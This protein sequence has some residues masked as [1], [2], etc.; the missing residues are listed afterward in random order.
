MSYKSFGE[1]LHAKR[2]EKGVSYRE[3]ADVIDVTAPYIS[4]MEKGRRNAPVMNKLK[5]ISAY[6]GLSEEEEKNMF[7]LA[8]KTKDD[9]PPDLPNY[10]KGND[11]VVFALRTAR[12][13]GA[14]EEDWQKFVD[15]LRQ[16]KGQ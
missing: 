6:F 8:G 10:I 11:N 4:D 1:F 12:D 14:S 15:E 16:R 2:M 3:M 5:K 9:L 13:L 7:D